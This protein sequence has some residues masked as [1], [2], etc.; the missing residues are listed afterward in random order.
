MPEPRLRPAAAAPRPAGRSI[1]AQIV[2]AVHQL[3]AMAALA[4]SDLPSQRHAISVERLPLPGSSARGIDPL[5]GLAD[6]AALRKALEEAIRRSS[7]DGCTGSRTK[8]GLILLDLDGFRALNVTFGA[9]AGDRALVHAARRLTDFLPNLAPP[10]L[11]SSPGQSGPG[12]ALAARIGDD[13]FALLLPGSPALPV[14]RDLADALAVM[15]LAAREPSAVPVVTG[16]SVG[17]CCYPDQAGSAEELLRGADA[18]LGREQYRRRPESPG[19][20]RRHS[21]GQAQESLLAELTGALAKREPVLHYQPKVAFDGTV[22]GVEGL[23]RWYTPRRGW[24]DPADLI[25]LAEQAGLMPCL[26]GYVLDAAARQSM[27]WR[28]AGIR[29]GIAVNIS[30][31]DLLVPGFVD[32]VADRLERFRLPPG[33]L[34]LEITERSLPDGWHRVAEQLS[35]LFR[36]GLSLSLDD[37]GTGHSSLERLR[38]S[39]VSEIKIDQSFVSGMATDERD[40]ALVAWSVGLA[41]SLG[42]TVVAEGVEDGRTWSRLEALGVDAVQGWLVSPAMPAEQASGWLRSRTVRGEQ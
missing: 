18:A 40:A 27:E 34:R 17:V 24:T 31:Q 29:T 16:V 28:S 42:L 12:P 33:A 36:M 6:R 41:R 4:L 23:L 5:T 19:L 32:G 37:F 20:L 15:V 30:P 7:A 8:V 38:R 25:P 14:L 2:A 10:S 26:T 35:D 3:Q 1:R 9:D 11:Q 39:P 22:V 13:E 21:A